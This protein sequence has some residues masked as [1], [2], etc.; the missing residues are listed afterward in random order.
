MAN[1]PI[2]LRRGVTETLTLA[3]AATGDG[4]FM[5]VLPVDLAGERIAWQLIPHGTVTTVSV[6]M[7]GSLNG[8]NFGVTVLDTTTLVTGELRLVIINGISHLK[9]NVGT[10]TGGGNV[11]ILIR[12]R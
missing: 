12:C 2:L 1:S 6:T 4:T 5:A 3:Q 8:S 11:D 7:L 10:L 9:I